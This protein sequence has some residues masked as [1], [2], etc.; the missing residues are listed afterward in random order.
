MADTLLNRL[1]HGQ[2]LE[3]AVGSQLLVQLDENPSTGYTWA[4]VATSEALPLTGGDF[5]A[6][7]PGSVGGGGLRSLRFDVAQAGEH[8][9][10]LALMRPWEGADAAVQRFNVTVRAHPA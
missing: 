8:A 6:A 7:A 4:P 10:E 9:L 5:T 1:H 2:T 3:A